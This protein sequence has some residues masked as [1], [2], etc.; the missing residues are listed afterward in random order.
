MSITLFILLAMSILT[1][2]VVRPKPKSVKKPKETAYWFRRSGHNALTPAGVA[3]AKFVGALGSFSGKMGAVVFSHNRAGTY[4]KRWTSPVN[5]ST[6][7]QS[8]VR[9]LFKTVSQL[10]STLQLATQ[11]S[12]QTLATNLGLPYGKAL[13]Q[14]R[15]NNMSLALGVVTQADP[16]DDQN[17]EPLAQ[18][19]PQS[20]TVL[21]ATTATVDMSSLYPG[22]VVPAGE[23]IIVSIAVKKSGVGVPRLRAIMLTLLEGAD[24]S[25][26]L[27]FLS[28]FT[29]RFGNALTGDQYQMEYYAISNLSGISGGKVKASVKIA[30]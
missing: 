27:D 3:S 4:I 7:A 26:P 19:V 16:A 11:T 1:Y 30:T 20:P 17:P 29:E 13:F 10:W 2:I 24:I 25:A 21:N 8:V 5:P 22:D 15:S 14:S 18:F 28:A 6:A 9:G 23:A 12:W